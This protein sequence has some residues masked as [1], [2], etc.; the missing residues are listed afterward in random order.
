MGAERGG[1]VCEKCCW[2]GLVQPLFLRLTGQMWFCKYN[3]CTP[4]KMSSD[5]R[6]AGQHT[7]RRHPSAPLFSASV[8]PSTCTLPVSF[9]SADVISRSAGVHR[10]FKVSLFMST[11]K[12]GL[13]FHFL[14]V[15]GP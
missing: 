7:R 5:V 6:N 1:G 15:F 4:G 10:K 3:I 8:P 12:M 2:F 14:F 11:E 13:I 9:L